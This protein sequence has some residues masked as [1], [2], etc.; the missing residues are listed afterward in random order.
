MCDI[1]YG[2]LGLG[3]INDDAEVDILDVV[4]LVNIILDYIDPNDNQIWA[5]DINNDDQINIQDIIM[6]V[7]L[8]LN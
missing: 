4:L 1:G 6:L 8:I 2:A 3:D 5:S 7:N